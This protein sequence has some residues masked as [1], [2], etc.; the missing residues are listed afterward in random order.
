MKRFAIRCTA[1]PASRPL[2]GRRGGAPDGRERPLHLAEERSEVGGHFAGP[3]TRRGHVDKPEE[4]RLQR[5]VARQQLHPAVLEHA[6]AAAAGA[7]P[8]RRRSAARARARAA[9]AR[10][11]ERARGRV[12]RASASRPRRY[13]LSRSVTIVTR[14]EF[15]RRLFNPHMHAVEFHGEERLEIVE[16]PD[17]SP[18][19]GELLIAP[20]AVGICGTDIEIFEGSLAYFRMGLAEFP[21]VPGH[22]WTGTVVDVGRGVTGFSAGDRVV[23]EVAIGCGVCVRCRRRAPAPVRAPDRD[24]HRAHGR[25]DGD[26][27]GLPGRVR[28]PGRVGAARGGVGGADLGGAA[29]GAPRAASRGSAC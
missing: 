13:G 28:A 8:G 1:T 3:R 27:D 26:A 5:R 29:R 19:E 7:R 22:E 10:A 23:G 18:G 9:P 17:P 16:R 4:R 21:I 25:R 12:G 2:T 20:T 6:R 24:R 11:P 15:V 14:P